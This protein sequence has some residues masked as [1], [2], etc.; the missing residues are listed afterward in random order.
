M[1]RCL[2]LVVTVA[3]LVALGTLPSCN[4]PTCGAGTKQV[5]AKD[6]SLQCEQAEQPAQ[7]TPCDVDMGAT[8]VGG[9]CVSAISCG[10]G[11]TLMNGVCVSTGGGPGVGCSKPMAGQACITGTIRNFTDGMPFSGTIHVSLYNPVEFLSGNPPIDEKDVTG[12]SYVFA[13][14]PPPSLMLVVV[15][16]GD[17]DHMNATFVNTATGAAGVTANN[18]YTVDA[19]TIPKAVTDSWKTTGGLDINNPTTGGAYV[20]IYY[21]DTK[22]APTNLVFNEKTPVMGVQ[23]VKDNAANPP[24]TKYFTTDLLTLG[25][26]TSTSA[27][28]AAVV[29]SPITGGFPS[30][31]GMGGGI[32]WETLPGGSAT[33]VVFVTRFH[34]N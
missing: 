29:P 16:T 11:T 3:G 32:T 27:I 25:T 10:A 18:Q 34:P 22:P 6:G 14:F 15:V 7:L 28:G 8:I 33:G 24:G 13:N 1:K 19:Y 9:H 21:S 5:Q 23:M 31:S 26:G 20:G 2:T 30:F 4:T 17:K 12:S